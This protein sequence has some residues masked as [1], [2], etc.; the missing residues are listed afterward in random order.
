M[1]QPICAIVVDDHQ[2]LREG[3]RMLLSQNREQPAIEVVGEAATG[4]E[5][6]ALLETARP[7]VVVLD[8]ALPGVLGNRCLPRRPRP[9]NPR[10]HPHHAR[11]VGAHPARARGRGRWIRRQRLGSLRVGP[12]DPSSRLRR[13]RPFPRG[14]ARPDLEIDSARAAGPG[15]G[16]AG[17]T[18]TARSRPIWGSPRTPSTPTG[19]TSWT[20][21]TSMMR[22]RSLASRSAWGFSR[23][24][25]LK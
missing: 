5:A 1:T 11:L 19:S 4:T 14:G 20:S 22:W 7:D 10:R 8:L 6:L 15:R 25:S 13:H 23:E 21:C 12:R 17:A 24:K 9:R 2:I 18:A 3:V 16:G